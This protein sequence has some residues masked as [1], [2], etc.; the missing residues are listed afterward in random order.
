MFQPDIT[1]FAQVHN[2]TGL[3][4]T[5]C[6]TRS[7]TQVG[8]RRSSNL[9]PPGMN[10]ARRLSSTSSIL[11]RPS[12]A[13]TAGSAGSAGD[14]ESLLTRTSVSAVSKSDVETLKLHNEV[15]EQTK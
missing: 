2:S 1:S 6:R 12:S 5:T 10:A 11:R 4:F 8:R 9:E 13:F 15:I 14:A 3:H 7:R